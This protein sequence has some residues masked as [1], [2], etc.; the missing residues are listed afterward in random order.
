MK[1]WIENPEYLK[2]YSREEDGKEVQLND[3]QWDGVWDYFKRYPSLWD[4]ISGGFRVP[5]VIARR[6][7]E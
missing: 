3:G 2:A 5:V 6:E 7:T 1:V 4:D